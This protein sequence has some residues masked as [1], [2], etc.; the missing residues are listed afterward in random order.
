MEGKT[1]FVAENFYILNPQKQPSNGILAV[2][3]KLLIE[4]KITENTLTAKCLVHLVAQRNF[5]NQ[6]KNYEVK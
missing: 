4:Y 1:N 5:A 2:R 3:E 6:P